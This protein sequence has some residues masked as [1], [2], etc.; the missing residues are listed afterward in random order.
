L[1]RS[2]ALIVNLAL[3]LAPG[4]TR[5]APLPLVPKPTT[6]T[7]P[8]ARGSGT[9]S[10]SQRQ[11]VEKLLRASERPPGPA[12]LAAIG[13]GAEQALVTIA[14]DKTAEA[15]LRGRA[16]GALAHAASPRARTFLMDVVTRGAAEDPAAA[17]PGDR[18]VLRRAAVALGWLA[19]PGAPPALG[20]LLAHADPEVRTDAAVG[21]GLTRLAPAA[22]L[23]RNHLA[24]EKDPKVRSHVARQL[25]AIESGLGLADARRPPAPSDPEAAPPTS[26]A[27]TDLPRS[28]TK[29]R[30]QAPPPPTRMQ[31]NR[32]RF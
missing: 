24:I 23:L 15:T 2:A 18:V 17:T 13:P 8:A 26:E 6:N 16:T 1:L 20:A 5:A 3:A 19:G 22:S 29:R 25:S 21:L 9:L 28:G 11:Q 27:P 12:D 32:S 31:P 14:A 30:T 4:L 7:T 10:G